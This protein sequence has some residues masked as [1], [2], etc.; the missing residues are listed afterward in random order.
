MDNSRIRRNVFVPAAI[1]LLLLTAAIT[2]SFHWYQ[3]QHL[4]E[5]IR[6]RLA[7]V[8]TMFEDQME[9]D[10]N[11][12]AG[13]TEFLQED[14]R[15]QKAFLAGDREGL[16]KAALPI[17]EGLRAKHR[18]THLY[19]SDVDRVCFLRVHEPTRHGDVIDRYTTKTA[20]RTGEPSHGIEL[21]PLGTFTLR[22]VHPWKSGDRL[23]G[24][25]E[26]G[27]E[28]EYLVPRLSS[29]LGAELIVTIDKAF[30]DKAKWEAGLKMLKREA[31][32][33]QFADFVVVDS[34]LPDTSPS[35]AALLQIPHSQHAGR[36]FAASVGSTRYSAGLVT[37]VDAGGSDVGNLVALVDVTKDGYA[38]RK[39]LSAVVAATVAIFGII[40]WLLW[41]Y[42]GRL[43][44]SVSAAMDEVHMAKTAAEQTAL[45]L[46]KLSRAVEQSPAGI[47]IATIQG[48]VE[49]GNT[50]ILEMTGYASNELVGQ[51]V[52]MLQSERHSPEFHKRILMV[53]ARG[54]IWR[55]EISI[56]KKDGGSFWGN[57]T[58]APVFDTQKAV[59]HF[60]MVAID[61]TEK[62]RASDA[63]Q[64]Y[65]DSL[66]K[67]AAE[68][69]RQAKELSASERKYRTLF[70]SSRDAIMILTPDEGFLD[71][72]PAAAKLFGCKDGAEFTTFSPA[73][74]S[75]ERQPDGGL[76]SVEAQEMMAMALR[77]GSHYF[78]WT[79]K[80]RDGSEFPATVLLT[81]MELEGKAVLQATVRDISEDN[82][83][84]DGLRNAQA[85]VAANSPIDE[86]LERS[87]NM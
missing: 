15:L 49:Y 33:D 34:T 82:W 67:A 62:K 55:G 13:L 48:T 23:I 56:R 31:S 75:P 66:A 61:A 20:A 78:E 84:F 73:E 68:I 27:E 37:L 77:N 9:S 81:R 41:A 54:E 1:G 70:D 45:R 11:A 59:S 29:I 6:D 24:Y 2:I 71:G 83:A 10:A 38:L 80:R 36:I 19:F 26:L 79:H 8:S 60:V 86:T 16:L 4:E 40:A 57:A 39:A 85:G 12:L 43:E 25:V 35:I 30:L 69:Q 28:I 76:S 17:F 14:A 32:W 64:E 74:L 63:M 52:E 58:F 7:M 18:V 21:G 22:V 44:Q 3:S 87:N 51:N 47:L 53:L 50:G 72:N 42:L 65:T 46:S 5:T